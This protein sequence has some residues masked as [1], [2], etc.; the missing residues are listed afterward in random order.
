MTVYTAAPVSTRVECPKYVVIPALGYGLEVPLVVRMLDPESIGMARLL[1][2]G[3]VIP[4]GA[5]PVLLCPTTAYGAVCLEH[6]MRSW[7][8]HVPRPWLVLV[9]DAPAPPAAAARYRFRALRSRLVGVTTIPYLPA[10]RGAESAEAAMQ[11]KD[12]QAAG[13][14]LRRQIER[15]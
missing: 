13:V 14:H 9:A 11:H 3:E 4:Y 12:V 5:Q 8:P 15:G 10:L 1:R 7:S 6:T 2:P